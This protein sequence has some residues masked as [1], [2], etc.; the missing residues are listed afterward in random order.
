MLIHDS[1][2]TTWLFADIGLSR[3]WSAC[4]NAVGRVRTRETSRSSNRPVAPLPPLADRVR[5]DLP[6]MNVITATTRLARELRHEYD[7]KQEAAG[8]PS[9]PTARIL[10]LSAWL[11]ELWTNWL[12]SGHAETTQRLLRPA[13]ERAIWEDI[14][15]SGAENLLLEVTAT[16]EAVC[17]SWN[18]LCAWTLPLDAAEWKDSADSETFHL[19]AREFRRRCF[20]NG[21]FSGA[22]LPAFVADLIGRGEVQVQENIEIKG[23]LEPTPVQQRLFDSLVWRGAKV[24]ERKLPDAVGNA[25][26]LGLT[27]GNREIRA[28]AEW[29]RRTLEG[30]PNATAPE[31]RI[32]VIVPDLSQCRSQIERVFAEEFHPRTR[33][34]PDLDPRRLFNISLGL[35][36]CEYPII[37][38]AFLAFATDPQEIPIEIAGRLVRSPFVHGAED[39]LTSRAL[40]DVALRSLGEPHV[41]LMDIIELA[42]AGDASCRCPRLASQLRSWMEQYKALQTSQMPSDWAPVLSRFLQEIGWPGD[43]GL[44]STEYQT[45]EVWNELFSELAGLDSISGRIP[46]GTAVGMMRRLASLRQFQPESEPAPVQILGVFEASGLRFDRLWIMGMHDNAWPA[47]PAPDPFLPFR[48][49]RRFNLPRSSPDQELEFAKTLTARLLSSAPTVVVSYPEREGDSDLRISPLFA[50]LPE[51]SLGELGLLASARHVEQLQRSSV[52][53]TLEDHSGPPCGDASLKGGT[54]LFKLQA[55]CPF[56]AFAEL[57]L[58]AKAPD[59]PEPG[60][61]ALDRGQVIHRILEQIWQQLQSHEGLLSTAEGR[62]ADIVRTSVGVEIQNLSANRRALRSPRFA[63]IEQARLERVIGKWLLLE[64]ER[65]PFTMLEQEERRRVTVGGIDLHIRADRV[66]RLEDGELVI[67]DYKTSECSPS[68]WEGPRPDEPQLPIYA[69]TADFLVAGVFFGRLKTG[70]VGFRGLAHSEGIIPGIRVPDG[71]PPLG[72]TIEEWRNV[73]DQL[74]QDFRAGRAMVDPKDRHRTCR[75]CALPTLCRIG[76]ADHQ[77]E[78][79]DDA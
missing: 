55:A 78:R 70:K 9:W 15:R 64:R 33:L 77:S 30:D 59:Q 18:L 32:G 20:E 48:L 49:Q 16:A 35:P 37:E 54:S 52:M 11:S 13:E 29:A 71:Q 65:Q 41:S 67:L 63:A 10:P 57:R 76:Q 36:V 22:E 62:L 50:A 74:G 68:D 75:Y 53:E 24:Q 43:R 56:K 5:L 17:D 2:R 25:V 79:D 14:V 66:D 34:R 69:V 73:L 44:D 26:C 1:E 58:G 39:E 61:S 45:L 72:H 60:L 31:F 8:L 4:P 47:A 7:R 19:W 21:W 27:D 12:Y 38:T 28:A 23:F 46:L 3:C 51:V 40:L 6:S 42:D